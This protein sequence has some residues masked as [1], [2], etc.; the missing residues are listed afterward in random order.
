MSRPEAVRELIMEVSPSE[1]A[2]APRQLA[3]PVSPSFPGLDRAAG[4]SGGEPCPSRT[5]IPVWVLVQ[6]RKLGSRESEIL[7]AYLSLRAEDLGNAWAGYDVHGAEIDRRI[8][9][10]ETPC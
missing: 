8:I 1:K 2:Q 9:E 3:G 10:N 6:A 4:V 7:R 5:R